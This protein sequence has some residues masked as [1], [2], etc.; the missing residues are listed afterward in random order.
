MGKVLGLDIGTDSIHAVILEE[1]LKG[2]RVS[3]AYRV[4]VHPEEPIQSLGL[5]LAGLEEA[6]VSYDRM[7]V[8]VAGFLGSIRLMKLPFDDPAKVRSVLPFELEAEFADGIAG[9]RFWFHQVSRTPG[10]EDTPYFC[11]AV[12]E[13]GITQLCDQLTSLKCRPRLLGYEPFASYNT[14]RFQNQTD[15]GGL[16]VLLDI[17][18]SATSINL[19]QDGILAY[20][21]VI[22]FGGRDFTA[23]IAEELN[24]SFADS[25]D[26]K[27]EYGMSREQ[28]GEG[29]LKVSQA[30]QS[31]LRTL[32]K[33]VD[34]TLG[35]YF[36]LMGSRSLCGITL[37]GGGSNLEGIRDALAEE[38]QIPITMGDPFQGLR[39][40][41]DIKGPRGSYSVAV[42]LALQALGLTKLDHN[43][44][45]R[46]P[47][48]DT[49]VQ[50]R[51]SSHC[52]ALFMLAFFFCICTGLEVGI[53]FW[54]YQELEEKYH[55]ETR[56]ILEKQ[57]ENF[58]SLG[59]LQKKIRE[60]KKLLE[61]FSQAEKSPI[62]VLNYLSTNEF[63]GIDLNLEEVHLENKDA[64]TRVILKGSVRYAPDIRRLE[65]L[66]KKVPFVR[67]VTVG[68]VEQSQESGRYEF[69]E[70]DLVL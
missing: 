14:L 24:M 54:T 58:N 12:S 53:V 69:K 70:I 49:F 7:A 61:E 51:L 11:L 63:S 48:V 62:D 31:A 32:L 66:L 52:T 29:D 57:K 41:A 15:E 46:R 55:A 3:A 16:R 38:Y 2:E 8:N 10:E 19:I 27:L 64:D 67:R 26:L 56:A 20:S 45:L 34:L 60:R 37:F 17:G 33:E 30:L 65:N 23:S 28:E 18:G 68:P 4:P 42:G 36:S 5:F 59:A 50:K 40:F 1:S 25:E 22:H 9:K 39:V 13:D 47:P 6:G 43:L 44:L 21:R 35:A